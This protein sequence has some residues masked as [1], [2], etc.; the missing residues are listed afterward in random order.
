MNL[1]TS[2][3]LVQIRLRLL[4]RLRRQARDPRFRALRIQD[5]LW[6]R[7]MVRY[8]VPGFIHR[9]CGCRWTSKACCL[10]PNLS[11]FSQSCNIPSDTGLRTAVSCRRFFVYSR[12]ALFLSTFISL[13]NLLL[14]SC[15]FLPFSPSHWF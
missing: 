4:H 11:R 15:P 9:L 7:R 6:R 10:L 13:C 5:G 8:G 1:T 3:T 2:L 14:L 12:G